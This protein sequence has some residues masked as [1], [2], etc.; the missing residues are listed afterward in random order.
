MTTTTIPL[1]LAVEGPPDSPATGNPVHLAII[2]ELFSNKAAGLRWC[3][4]TGY[5]EHLI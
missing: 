2:I 1:L 5:G 4:P 3:L